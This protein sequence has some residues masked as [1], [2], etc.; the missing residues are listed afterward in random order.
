M[1]N[2]GGG[3]WDGLFRQH[4]HAFLER[5]GK[6]ARLETRVAEGTDEDYGDPVYETHHTETVAEV[7]FRGS[8]EF[9]REFRGL[10]ADIAAV[11]YIK[12]DVTLPIETEGENGDDPDSNSGGEAT[13]L[14]ISGGAPG[15]DSSYKIFESHDENNGKIR[16]HCVSFDG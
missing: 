10:D 15:T 1:V 16:L 14:H 7:V 5:T 12:D 13:R 9:S 3:N 6:Q 2:V 8:P 11:A 4:T